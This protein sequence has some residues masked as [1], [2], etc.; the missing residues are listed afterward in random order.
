MASSAI[1]IFISALLLRGV[2]RQWIH[3]AVIAGVAAATAL[4][5]QL[6]MDFDVKH[7]PGYFWVPVASAVAAAIGRA[8]AWPLM[9]VQAIRE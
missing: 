3:V 5:I 9:R 4:V 2:G 8:A 6:S 7:Q 1:A